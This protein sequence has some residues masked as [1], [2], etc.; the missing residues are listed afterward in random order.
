MPPKL[1]SVLALAGFLAAA[2]AVA[3]LGGFATASSVKTWYPTL[4][5]PAWTP[6]GWLFGPAWTVLYTIMA[7]VAW[8]VWRLPA[9]TPAGPTG[10]AAILRLWWLQL[11]L[12]GAWSWAFFYFRT[13]AAGLLVIGALLALIAGLQPRLAR[14]DRPSALLWTPYV[15]WVAF[16]ACLNLSIWNRN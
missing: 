14:A 16:A 10:R 3:A 6:P 11:G 9:V 5:K 15:L 13:P 1:R 4:A 12:N 2:F 7:V 8:R